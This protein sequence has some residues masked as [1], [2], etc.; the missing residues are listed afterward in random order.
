MNQRVSR[1]LRATAQEKDDEKNADRHAQEPQNDVADF[2]ALVFEI[3]HCRAPFV[4][5][6]E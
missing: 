3:A 4:T 6:M 1:R 5:L 2:A